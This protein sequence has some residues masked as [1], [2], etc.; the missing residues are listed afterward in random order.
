MDD[1]ALG[2]ERNEETYKRSTRQIG[3]LAYSS[4]SP[5]FSCRINAL[6]PE[7]I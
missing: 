6:S 4:L 2:H 5:I 7:N 1:L 3:G